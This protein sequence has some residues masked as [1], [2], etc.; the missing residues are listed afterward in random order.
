[1]EKTK[2]NPRILASEAAL[3]LNTSVQNIH[4][5]IK[6]IGLPTQNSQNRVSFTYRSASK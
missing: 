4:K 1:M 6:A 3:I 5:K 2:I